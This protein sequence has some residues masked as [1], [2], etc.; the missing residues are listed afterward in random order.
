M[1][2]VLLALFDDFLL[3][4][5]AR[6]SLVRDG[7]PTDRVELTAGAEPGRAGVLPASSP[8]E[9]FYR[10]FCAV[11]GPEEHA[12]A[13]KLA[14]RVDHGGAVV[15]VHPRGRTET[16]RATQILTEHGTELLAEQGL[17]DQ[18]LER[19]AADRATDPWV[20]ALWLPPDPNTDCLYCRLSH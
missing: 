8:Q 11:L 3:A 16:A 18:L 6:V 10:Y 20:R 1:S 4:E 12:A 5:R 15:T 14:Q 19:A 17:D 9:R 2:A 7:F 13:G